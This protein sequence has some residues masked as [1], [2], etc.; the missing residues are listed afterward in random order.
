MQSNFVVSVITADKPGI[1]EILSSIINKNKGNWLASN[2]TRLSGQ[3]A[4]IVEFSCPTNFSSEIEQDLNRLQSKGFQ[5]HLAKG[6]E[7]HHDTVKTVSLSNT[8]MLLAEI[9]TAS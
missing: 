9:F 5:L 2:F 3:F 8:G 1:I 7:H 4:G 6:E